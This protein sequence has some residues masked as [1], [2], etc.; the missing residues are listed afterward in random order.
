[1]RMSCK[2]NLLQ[3]TWK[4][5]AGRL[6]VFALLDPDRLRQFVIAGRD[7]VYD[8]PPL[9]VRVQR[10]V[11]VNRVIYYLNISNLVCFFLRF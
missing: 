1:M 11:N 5:W 3:Y 10:P 9:A 7:L 4:L 6:V 2:E 8:D